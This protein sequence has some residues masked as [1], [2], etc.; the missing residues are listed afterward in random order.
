MADHNE[1]GFAKLDSYEKEEKAPRE[2]RVPPLAFMWIIWK[3][4][5]K[6]AFLKEWSNILLIVKQFTVSGFLLV[7]FRGPYV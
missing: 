3:E 5:N 2:T 7:F 6:G 4:R 1:G